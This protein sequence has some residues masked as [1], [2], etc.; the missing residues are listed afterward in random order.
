MNLPT[1]LE[2]IG[3]YAFY[4]CE[5][6]QSV[7]LPN[8]LTELGDGAFNNCL[9]LTSVTVEWTEPIP[10]TSSSTFSNCDNCIL[11]VPDGC[12]AA[13]ESADYWK[14]FKEIKEMSE[15]YILGD[16]NNDGTISVTDVGMIISYILQTNPA[17]FNKDAA[18]LNGDGT[19]SV[20]DVGALIT[21]ILQVK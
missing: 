15:M 17:G 3:N 19:I 18:D 16:V 5:N 12:K 20:T 13:Y 4:C 1:T 2:E 14:D 6:L 9:N 21:K 7:T 10:L 11:Y 8:S